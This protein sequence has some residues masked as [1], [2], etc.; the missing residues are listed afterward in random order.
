MDGAYALQKQNVKNVA[1][2]TLR[3]RVQ[4]KTY[5]AANISCISYHIDQSIFSA[6]FNLAAVRERIWVVLPEKETTTTLML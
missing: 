4:P 6:Q 1:K 5:S 2:A 3:S